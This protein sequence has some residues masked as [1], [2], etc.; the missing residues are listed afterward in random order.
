M[1]I[2]STNCIYVWVRSYFWMSDWQV[3]EIYNWDDLLKRLSVLSL[4]WFV[5]LAD[6]SSMAG[7]GTLLVICS[8]VLELRLKDIWW[9]DKYHSSN[10]FYITKKESH[11]SPGFAVLE[12]KW[13]F[14]NLSFYKFL[15]KEFDISMLV[16]LAWR[17]AL[18]KLRVL[19]YC[20][21][22]SHQQ[23]VKITAF[24]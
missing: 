23:S 12:L 16:T 1:V 8:T 5:H 18:C 11:E 2:R 7:V 3:A 13:K 17:N 21:C 6:R 14:V 22:K 19:N 24:R 9:G 4:D 10:K 20:W 15:Q